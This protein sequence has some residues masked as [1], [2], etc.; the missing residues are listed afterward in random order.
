MDKSEIK[1]GDKLFLYG[2]YLTELQEFE[3][4][5]YNAV[6]G[7]MTV[8][9][10]MVKPISTMNN[11]ASIPGFVVDFLYERSLV[12]TSQAPFLRLEMI[13]VTDKLARSLPLPAGTKV[14]M[15]TTQQL[16]GHLD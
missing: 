14:W 8:G 2:Q 1:F 10:F 13:D 7:Y 9:G 12:R 5:D 16:E 15:P 11:D 3:D 6:M 4:Y